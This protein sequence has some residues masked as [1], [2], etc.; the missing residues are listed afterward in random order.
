MPVQHADSSGAI[1]RYY[2]GYWYHPEFY[3]WGYRPWGAPVYW[4]IGAWGWGGA[5]WYG[6]YGG[7]SAPYP[8]YTSPVFWLTD[9]LIA[10][11]LQAAYAAQAEANADAMASAGG[12]GNAGG[13]DPS[14]A[15]A[16]N[17]VTLTPEVKQAIAEE[18]KAELAA[19]QAE[20][21]Q[22]IASGGQAAAAT[23]APTSS[24]G[25]VPPA[26]NPARRTFVVA[27]DLSVVAN[28]QECGLT[29]GDVIIRLTDTPD[30]DNMVNASVSASKK[31]DCA[32][33]QTVAVKVDDLQE[34][35]NNFAEQLN[36][37]LGELAKK[38][39]TGGIP[40]APDTSTVV[41]DVPP[42]PP[43][44]TAEKTLQDQQQAADQTEAQVKQEATSDQAEPVRDNNAFAV[45]LYG[46]LG[47]QSG[48][49]FFSPESIST[50]LAMTYAGARADTASEMAKTLHFALP[51]GQSH[52]AMSALLRDR[53]AAHDGYQL[54]EADALWVE[55]SYSLLPEF[56]K[57]NKDNYEAGLNQVDFKNATEESRQTINLWVEQRTENKIR[58]LLGPGS[59]N[60]DTRLVLTNAIYFKGDWE[61]PF[62]KEDTKDEDFHLTAAQAIKTP[63]MHMTSGIHGLNYFD[64]D[65]FQAL[66]IP[67]KNKE[68][69]MIVL[70]PK[71]IEG[72]SAFE[73]SLSPAK[74]Q[75]L[76]DQL[77]PAGKVIVTMPKFKIEAQFG[78]GDTLIAMGMKEAFDRNMADFSGMASR[79]TM[80]RDGNLYISAVIHKAYVDVNEEGTEA[81]AATA[82][83]V[84]MTGVP[85]RRPSIIFCA[86]HPFMFLI[87]DNRSGSILFIG[88]V[89]NPSR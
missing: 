86:D 56:L 33:G 26:L 1:P 84:R 82:V 43:D 19:Q 83:A 13:G 40:K 34:M 5:P 88:R 24:S 71:A 21:A 11:N 81:A 42:P 4:G 18:V 25:E 29:Q 64:G 57:L 53:N 31:S 80:Q 6:F 2:P 79:K 78:L 20:A 68:L 51:P 23:P 60:S 39:G 63:L 48:N 22:S 45:E 30:A 74:M 67:Y 49:L 7:F 9:Y 72:L 62:K 65:S 87:R 35:Q 55:K 32:A 16:S 52:P 28:G 70:L 61:K 15:A 59:L 3:A 47:N 54:K 12:G 89:T 76:L 69:S 8:Y 27:S 44:A 85:S 37:G 58:E 41:S 36:T 66:E 17:S 73:Q 14:P 46:Q 38:Q 10:A 77:R 50:A 75:Q